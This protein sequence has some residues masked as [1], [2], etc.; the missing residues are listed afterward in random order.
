MN[1]VVKKA[2][3]DFKP[4]GINLATTGRFAGAGLMGGSSAAAA[5]LFV[6]MLKDMSDYKARREQAGA[7]DDNTLTLTLP[8]RA[9]ADCSAGADMATTGAEC[10]PAKDVKKKKHATDEHGVPKKL[11]TEQTRSKETAATTPG[12][13]RTMHTGQYSDGVTKRANWQ[14]LAASLL[15]LGG[16]GTLGFALVNKVYDKRREKELEGELTTAKQEYLNQLGSASGVKEAQD[17]SFSTM[18]YP[19][20]LA[21]L[22]FLMGT[23]GTAWMTKKFLDEYNKTPANTFKPV[24]RPHVDRILFQTEGAANGESKQ[25]SAPDD[26]RECFDAALGVYLDM[27]SGSADVLGDPKC[28]SVMAKADMEEMYKMANEDFD[29]LMMFLRTNPELA[30]TVRNVSMDQHPILKYFKWA[31]G[32]PGLNRFAD[33]KVREGLNANFGP[34]AQIMN[35]VKRSAMLPIMLGNT[36]AGSAGGLAASMLNT[37]KAESDKSQQDQDQAVAQAE[38]SQETKEER[39]ARINAMIANIQVGAGDP[40]AAEFV[41]ENGDKLRNILIMLAEEGKI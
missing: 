12:Q 14:T 22:M 39:D 36:V 11:H 23:G 15:A 28:A 9:G 40:D 1:N 24:Q 35:Q 30:K 3:D 5:L 2:E 26:S 8:K 41:Q 33:M 21:A 38:P 6:K 17:K 31:A 13:I 29:N 16:G 32:L 7:D 4:L 19:L 27:C 34:E 25:A 37:A 18:D 10:P 20:G